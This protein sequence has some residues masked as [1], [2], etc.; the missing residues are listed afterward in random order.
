MFGVII[1]AVLSLQVSST[2]RDVVRVGALIATSS[3]QPASAD[4]MFDPIGAYGMGGGAGSVIGPVAKTLNGKPNSGILLLRECFDGAL[5]QDGLIEWYEEHLS[6]EFQAFFAGGSV[7]L[8][9][10]AYLSV[11][12]DLLKSFP[13]FTYT[14]AAPMKYDNGPTVV[15]WTAVVKGTHTAAPYSP[16]ISCCAAC[17][18]LSPRPNATTL[19]A[20]CLPTRSCQ[21]FRLSRLARPQWAAKTTRR[22]SP[23]LLRRARASPKSRRSSWRR[24]QVAKASLGRSAFIFKPVATRPSCQQGECFCPAAVCHCR[25]V[26][27]DGRH[28]APSTVVGV[29]G[30][31]SLRAPGPPRVGPTRRGQIRYMYEYIYVPCLCPNQETVYA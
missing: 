9:K 5:P 7:V 22:E 21:V 19:T 4:L 11:T 18:M 23:S 16:V 26:S 27:S 28:L 20:A 3:A 14:R 24:Y 30:P 8:S 10:A 25:A 17:G 31:G 12:A 15:S 1:T 6:P 2:R 29:A 13:D